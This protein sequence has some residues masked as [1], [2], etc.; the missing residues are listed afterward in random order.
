M[1]VHLE[2]AALIRFSLTNKGTSFPEE[3]R[4]AFG[5][6]GLLPPYVTTL[7]EQLERTYVAFQ[8]EPTPLAKYTYLRGLQERNEILYYAL[9]QRTSPRCSPSSTRR[10]SATR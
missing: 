9:L 6:D 10:P 2:G 8:R 7:E 3:E 5:I 1:R 4:I